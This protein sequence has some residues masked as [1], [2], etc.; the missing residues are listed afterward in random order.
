[1]RHENDKICGQEDQLLS[2]LYEDGTVASREEFESHLAECEACTDEFAAV[3]LARFSVYEW[4]KEEFVPMPTPQIV[5]PYDAKPVSIW[6]GLREAFSFN[7]ATASLAAA[8]LLVIA[9]FGAYVVS[10]DNAG[11]AEVNLANVNN[12]AAPTPANIDVSKPTSVVSNDAV[13]PVKAMN[14]EPTRVA[15]PIKTV[16]AKRDVRPSQPMIRNDA[17]N[18]AVATSNNNRTI[19]AVDDDS[20]DTSLRLTDLFDGEDTRY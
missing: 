14:E 6:A 1:M 8:S 19:N 9:A 17:K 2:Y 13:V 5:I 11:V 16:Q 20:E 10:I 3:S 15:R 12:V 7:W 4:H 18:A